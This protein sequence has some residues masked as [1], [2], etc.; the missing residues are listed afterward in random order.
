MRKSSKPT[1]SFNGSRLRADRE[2][3]SLSR[4]RVTSLLHKLYGIRVSGR[5]IANHEHGETEPPF[6]VAAAY[7]R[8][9]GV[10]LEEFIQHAQ[11]TEDKRYD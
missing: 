3:A 2:A 11:P 8:L 6:A 1:P 5:T 10:S 9:F 7:A 4:V